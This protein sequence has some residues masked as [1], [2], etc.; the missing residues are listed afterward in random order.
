MNATKNTDHSRLLTASELATYIKLLRDFRNWSQEQLGAISGLNVRTIQRVEQGQP[1]SLDTR[2]ALARAFEI[3][4]I[5]IFNKPFSIPNEKALQAEKEKFDKENVTLTAIPV[6]TGRQLA[7]LAESSTMDMSEPA[8]DLPRQADE[9]FAALLDYFREYRDCVDLYNETAK[10]DIYDEM[11]WHIDN[12]KDQGVSLRYA[13]RN[14]QVK[15]GSEATSKPMPVTVLYLV[16]FLIGNE[17]EEF[18]MPKSG[19]IRL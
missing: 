14:L 12:L 16:G 11:Q 1:A 8:S 19:R 3:E 15:W 10:F 7:K 4:D 9:A 6:T 18:A 17:P 5:D 2:R 13:E